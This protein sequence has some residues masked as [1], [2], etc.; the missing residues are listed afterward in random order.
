[1]D[2]LASLPDTQEVKGNEKQKLKEVS[3]VLM[4]SCTRVI[5][6]NQEL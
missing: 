3:P 1:M 4:H 2:I 6:V 5:V